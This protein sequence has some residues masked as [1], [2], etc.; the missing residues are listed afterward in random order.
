MILTCFEFTLHTFLI[1]KA[2]M[3]VTNLSLLISDKSLTL[4]FL[5]AYEMSL[6]KLSSSLLF[7]A[8][9]N[10]DVMMFSSTMGI[11]TVRGV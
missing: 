8:M 7:F 3:L 5:I 2:S 11:V 9:K 1:L 6:I 4:M 10:F